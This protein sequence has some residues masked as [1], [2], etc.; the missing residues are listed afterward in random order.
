MKG[1]LESLLVL[2]EEAIKTFSQALD[3]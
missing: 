2:N 3:I 1:N